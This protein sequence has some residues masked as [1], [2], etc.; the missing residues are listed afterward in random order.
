MSLHIEQ[1]ESEGIIILDLKG[2]LTL[3]QAE[4][5]C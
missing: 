4:A 2:S 3:G 5:A 1:R